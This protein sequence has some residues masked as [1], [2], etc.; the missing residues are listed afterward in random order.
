MV[1]FNDG[2]L[3]HDLKVVLRVNDCEYTAELSETG[4]SE[5]KEQM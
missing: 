3:R 5:W 1:K 2:K 4:D